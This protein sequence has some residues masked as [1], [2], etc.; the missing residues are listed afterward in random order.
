MKAYISHLF[1]F[2][3]TN[4]LFSF[5]VC[6]ASL[7]SQIVT[8]FFK[9]QDFKCLLDKA[10]NDE[11]IIIGLHEFKFDLNSSWHTI[12]KDN[13]KFVKTS[14]SPINNVHFGAEYYFNKV[15]INEN[16]TIRVIFETR[17]NP[18]ISSMFKHEYEATS[19]KCYWWEVHN[20]D[21]YS[22]L[23]FVAFTLKLSHSKIVS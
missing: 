9:N 22:P 1:L 4:I 16:N 20:S 11:E 21:Q 19:P 6:G 17:Y 18:H 12:N 7:D 3:F 10:K 5:F 8:D 15:E 14:D 2:L 13:I 23:Y